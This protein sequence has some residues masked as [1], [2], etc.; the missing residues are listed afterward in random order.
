MSHS[1]YS[2]NVLRC[3]YSMNN[4]LPIFPQGDEICCSYLGA[5]QALLMVESATARRMNVP[6]QHEG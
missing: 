1:C 6:L 4:N 2:P 5:E 3:H